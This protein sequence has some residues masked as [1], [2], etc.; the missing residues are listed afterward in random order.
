MSTDRG[1][2]GAP[3]RALGIRIAAPLALLLALLTPALLAPVANADTIAAKR[4]E[5]NRVYSSIVQSEQQ[6][7]GVIQKYDAARLQL[8]TTKSAIAYNRARLKMARHNLTASQ[9]DLAGALIASYKQGQPDALQAVLASHSLSQMFDEINLM[10]RATHF[11]AATVLRVDQYRHEV[12]TRE[13]ALAHERTRRAAAVREQ[14]ARQTEIQYTIHANQSR[15]S[16]LKSDIRRLVLQ[17]QAE[18]RAAVRARALAASRALQAQQAQTQVQATQ[19]SGL[20]A[21]LGASADA[22]ATTDVGSPDASTSDATQAAPPPSS[23]GARAAQIALGEQGIPYVWGGESP[24]GFD[25]SGLVAWSYSQIGISLPHYTGALWNSG[26]HVS[27]DQLEPGDLVFFHGESHVGIYIG[28][29]QFVQAPHTGDVVKVSSLSDSWY[30]GG[31]DGAV[32]IG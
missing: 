11:N 3:D 15:L 21:G 13:T 19:T 31:Y 24:S 29:G 9:R 6:L 32:R 1:F 23:A 5:A 25:C 17:R 20:T 27:Q 4:Q 26:T 10:K 2:R 7:E 8:Q 12:I 30:A 22:L 16:G 18:E 14:H 28:G